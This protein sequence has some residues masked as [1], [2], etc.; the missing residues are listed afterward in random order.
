MQA[1]ILSITIRG[2]DFKS[3][4]RLQIGLEQGYLSS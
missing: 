2:R 1:Y 3:G 4:Q